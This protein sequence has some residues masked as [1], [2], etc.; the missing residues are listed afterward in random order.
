MAKNARIAG[1]GL[2]APKRIIDNE[3]AAR[4]AGE[5]ISEFM[6][7]LGI[8]KR[9]RVTEN[10][11]TTN[12]ATEAGRK[13]IAD[14]GM[15]ADDI[16]LLIVSTDTPDI[17]SPQTAASTAGE[18]GLR[19]W[20]PFFDINSSCTGFVFATEVAVNMIRGNPDFKNILVISAYCM[21]KF[22]PM[23]KGKFYTVFADGAGAAIFSAT[24]KENTGYLISHLMG[25]GTEW[26]RLGVYVGGTRFP[27]TV[28]RL[29]GK[30]EVAPGLTFFRGELL[31]RNPDLWPEIIQAA[32]QKIGLKK[33]D[34]DRYIFTQINL[35]SI[36]LTCEN[37]GIPFEKTHNIMSEY[38]YTG[39][40]CIIM[41]LDDARRN[42]Q[43][44]EGDLVCLTAAGVGYTM[45]TVLLKM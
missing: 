32:L 42:G 39:N 14:A 8:E 25:D 7:A 23:E 2:Y 38:G 12:L 45:G 37:L 30:G 26:D 10:E 18:L 9:R 3:E 17:I 19:K 44:K 28:E 21:S 35:S 22:A 24:E 34:V 6:E 43:V 29:E 40:A 1:T 11:S 33:E 5:D 13:A 36:K 41:A 27:A 15:E 20:V 31:N 16:D 4:I